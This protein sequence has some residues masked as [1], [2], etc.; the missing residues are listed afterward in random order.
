MKI[1]I[2]R[3]THEIGGTCVELESQ[4]ERI[5][6]DIGSPLNVSDTDALPLYPVLGFDRPNSSLLGVVISHPHQDHYGLAYRLP[7]ETTFLIGKAAEAILAAAD[8][9]TPAGLNLKHVIHL[10]DRQPVTLGPFTITPYLVDHSAYDSYAVLVEADGKRLFYSGDFRAHG[11]K[12]KLVERLIADAPKNV[13]MLLMEGTTLGRIDGKAYPTE[14][15]LTKRF[16]E[17]I[18]KTQGLTLVWASG[19]NIDRLVTLFK[20]CRG[21]KRTLVLDMYTAQVLRAIGNSNL[22][23]AEWDGVKVFLPGSQRYRIIKE[24]RFDLAD[25]FKPYRVYPEQLVAEAQS[26]VMLFRPSMIRDLQKMDGLSIGRLIC[27]VWKGYLDDDRNPKLIDW[28]KERN[29]PLDHCHTSGHA[30][31]EDLVAM[32]NAFPEASVVPVHTDVPDRFEQQF[33]NAR[34]LEDKQWADV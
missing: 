28:L 13:D 26:H 10:Q 23:Q 17:L 33:G 22:P 29:I 2:H 11:R 21:A 12:S 1:C 16:V 30:A 25:H 7:K 4:G 32:R 18:G 6:L 27:S 8:L 9:F 5:V 19:Q 24:E 3:G 14:D 20:A 34:C 31:V 15:D